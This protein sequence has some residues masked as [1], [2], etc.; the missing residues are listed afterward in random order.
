MTT[1]RHNSLYSFENP[2]STPSKTPKDTNGIVTMVHPDEIKHCLEEQA[3]ENQKTLEAIYA[4]E[5]ENQ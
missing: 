1:I 5:R 3:Q 2:F 4:M